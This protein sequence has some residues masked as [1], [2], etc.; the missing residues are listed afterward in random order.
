MRDEGDGRGGR[1]E[2]ERREE[3]R[4]KGGVINPLLN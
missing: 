4:K 1:G 3:E 2:K